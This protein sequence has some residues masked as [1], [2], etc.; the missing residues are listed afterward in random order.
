MQIHSTIEAMRAHSRAARRDRKLIGCVPTMGALHEGHLS[1]VRAAKSR[2][3]FVVASIFV[4]PTQ[5]APN[6]DL[7]KYP[8]NFDRD[9]QL[10][11]S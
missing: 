6:E 9:R 4:N 1:L 5:F 2:C 7:A 11:G 10:L 3:E 8:R